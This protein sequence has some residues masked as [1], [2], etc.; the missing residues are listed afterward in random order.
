M[1][2]EEIRKKIL[3]LIDGT[4]PENFQQIIHKHLEECNVC[5][6]EFESLRKILISAKKIKVPEYDRSFWNSRY[7]MLLSKAQQRYKKHIFIKRLKIVFGFLGIFLIFIVSKSYLK[8]T[9]PI[10]PPVGE[11]TYH[12]PDDVLS[13]KTLLLPVDEMKK[14][15]E[16]LEPEDQMTILAEYLN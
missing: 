8:E 4:L 9:E 6:N 1:K 15:F 14:I 5:R 12:I 10:I 3:D 11:I 13:E 7:E 16:F 2:C